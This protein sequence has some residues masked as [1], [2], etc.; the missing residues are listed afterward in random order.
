MMKNQNYLFRFIVCLFCFV[1]FSRW[2]LGQELPTNTCQDFET[3]DL[4]TN[5]VNSI[6]NWVMYN[7]DDGDPFPT[8]PEK[9]EIVDD[10]QLNSRIITASDEGGRTF[11]IN[12]QD[13]DGNWIANGN[14]CFC[15]DLK[16]ISD[17]SNGGAPE[18]VT[19][20]IYIFHSLDRSS[21]IDVID[22]DNQNT[23]P[24]FGFRFIL[25]PFNENTPWQRICLPVNLVN[26][27]EPLP[28]NNL[29]EWSPYGDALGGFDDA[30]IADAWNLTIQDVTEIGFFVDATNANQREIIGLDNICVGCD[31]P[32]CGQVVEES[33]QLIGSCKEPGKYDYTFQ[34]ENLSTIETVTSIVIRNVDPAAYSVEQVV[35]NVGLNTPPHWT[36]NNSAPFNMAPIPSGGQSDPLEVVIS[37][38]PVTQ[39]TDVC[40]EIVFYSEGDECCVF[41]HCVTLNPVDPCTST[42][43]TIT[44]TEE[45]CCYNLELTNTFCEDYFTKVITEISTPGVVFTGYS[46]GGTWTP[47]LSGDEKQI[48][49]EHNGGTLPTGTIGDMSFCVGGITSTNQANPVIVVKWLAVDLATGEESVVCTQ[50]ET[51]FCQPCMDFQI[52]EEGIICNNDG[53][54]TVNF[55]VTNNDNELAEWLTL[56]AKTPEVYFYP[57]VFEF[58]TP[59]G[60]GDT[61]SGSFILYDW[62]ANPLPPGSVISFKGILENETG[63]CC[64]MDDLSFILPDCEELCECSTYEIFV[65]DVQA[66]YDYVVN[67]GDGTITFTPN[68]LRPCD[69]VTWLFSGEG[70][71][72]QKRE[73]TG[74]DP[75]VF[76]IPRNGRFQVCMAVMRLD[77]EGK[78]CFP[79]SDTQEFC[80]FVS[81]T[82]STLTDPGGK[83]ADTEVSYSPAA[84]DNLKPNDLHLYPNPA[85]QEVYLRSQT[86]GAA[87]L[88]LFDATGQ[89]LQV[90]YPRL[91]KGQPVSVGVG[92]LTDGLYIL[93]LTGPDGQSLQKRF[94]KAGR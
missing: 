89:L 69:T 65:N 4:T 35:P 1:F 94:V 51:V 88:Q 18:E 74:N 37:G 33:A 20:S 21:L 42:G 47:T 72:D 34:V 2:T 56:E 60:Q 49:W 6:G 91:E 84:F 67:C 40:F 86:E 70:V 23:N 64:H 26:S 17:G 73:S 24:E 3:I 16:L 46:G 82:C 41:E 85:G 55:T 52:G 54:Y 5:P 39:P 81:I 28:S 71:D 58:P 80:N 43:V 62:N 78:S 45:D 63:W 8:S 7:S 50:E 12:T 66:G 87:I 57:S 79:P 76:P 90:L 77:G 9:I 30:D 22:V 68:A 19:S 31:E 36:L 32:E 38:P 93:R 14:T 75:V 53:T 29:G 15:F 13:Y 11:L 27:G 25:D 48:T 83:N 44:E 59:L 10:A 92:H 61:Y